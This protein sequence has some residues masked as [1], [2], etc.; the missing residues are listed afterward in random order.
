[1]QSGESIEKPAVDYADWADYNSAESES[2]ANHH[3]IIF[4]RK[5][6]TPEHEAFLLK[7]HGR[8]DLNPLPSQDLNDPLNW[9]EWRKNAQLAL[10]AFHSFSTTFIASGVI[11][12][13]S[14]FAEDYGVSLHACTY[15]TSC[16]ILMLGCIPIF[17]TP[18]M[19]K[20][21][22]IKI[23][24]IS[25]LGSCVFNIGC[26]FCKTYGAQ[27]ACRILCAVFISPGVAMGGTI[28]HDVTF[29]HERAAKTGWWSL[30]Y[31]LGVPA[32]PLFMGFVVTQ[33]GHWKYM[34]VVF[35]A[36]NFIQFLVYLFAG[37][38]TAYDRSKV[39]TDEVIE[40]KGYWSNLVTKLYKSHN[41]HPEMNLL[42]LKV[43]LHPILLSIK[44][45][46]VA[47][48]AVSYGIVFGYSNVACS[49]ELPSVFVE[50]FGFDAQQI[51]LQ[52]IAVII[53]SFIGEIIG[54]R[55]SDIFMAY[56]VKKRSG[57]DK[58][59]VHK[60]IEDRIWISYFG[61]VLAVVG[62]IVFGV[63]TQNARQ[64]HWNVTPL[65]GLCLTSLG[66]QVVTTTMITYAIDS[67]TANATHISLFITF[68]RQVIGFV[69][70]FYFTAMFNN[71]GFATSFGIMAAI[72]GF[73]SLGIV[74]VTHI[75]NR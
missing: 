17:F 36:T 30:L 73:V 46:K 13:Y 42:S 4:H 74:I 75:I 53:G 65:V 9:P 55:I 26:I 27:L 48:A 2:A 47:V 34:F 63:Q 10:V 59:I 60:K 44:N 45:Y 29:A 11:P 22:Q 40:A 32:G 67:D 18:I 15:F 6:I 54:G 23:F 68:L 16:Q 70:P 7:H 5:H 8:T 14:S 31:T 21:G 61:Y 64:G 56:C 3:E 57:G 41:Y 12:A 71:L 58:E 69:G 33:T 51:G 62:L 38:E 49:V 66:N 28:V 24:L 72:E 50:K 1:M 25:T 39:Q 43:Y 52:N 19:V 37:D 35:A 20:Y